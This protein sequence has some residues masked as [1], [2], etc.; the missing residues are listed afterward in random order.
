MPVYTFEGR[1]EQSGEKV[2]GMREAVSH[3]M[4]GQDL[5]TD[6]ILLTRFEEKH[7]RLPGVTLLSTV[8]Q[9]VPVLEKMLF[10][11]YFALR[12]VIAHR[13]PGEGGADSD[14]YL[15]SALRGSVSV[16]RP[17]PWG[18]RGNPRFRDP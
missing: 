18:W 15:P 5:L 17:G 13:G 1:N 4:L 14:I 10:A 8:F 11:R 16:Q 2:T 9:R 12:F 7:Q 6:G 3:A